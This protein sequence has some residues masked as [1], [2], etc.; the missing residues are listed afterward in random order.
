[1]K[2]ATPQQSANLSAPQI[3]SH[4]RS[5]DPVRALNSPGSFVSDAFDLL[6]APYIRLVTTVY[7]IAH[8]MSLFMAGTDTTIEI[9]IAWMTTT[10]EKLL[11]MIKT[12]I[13]ELANDETVQRR[14]TMRELIDVREYVHA[15]IENIRNENNR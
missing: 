5:A 6:L 3:V 12:S 9:G 14:Q 8:A 2:A 7:G 11:N 10:R 13:D 4:R 1:V 15:A